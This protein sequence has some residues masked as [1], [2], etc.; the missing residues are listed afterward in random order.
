M[1]TRT[2]RRFIFIFT[3]K[4]TTRKSTKKADAEDGEE[5]PKKTAAKKTTKKA[6]AEEG[7][8]KPKKTTR[9]KKTEEEA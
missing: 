5:K 1:S 6:D 3:W 4:T 8:E 2:K 9:K 7:E